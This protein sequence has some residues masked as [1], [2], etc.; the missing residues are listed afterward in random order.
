M[1]ATLRILKLKWAEYANIR[2]NKMILKAHLIIQPGRTY[3]FIVSTILSIIIFKYGCVE[4]CST[5]APSS[6]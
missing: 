6:C 5:L 4:L 2:S 3:K 1:H